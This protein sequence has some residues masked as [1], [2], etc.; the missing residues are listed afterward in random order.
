MS[1]TVHPFTRARYRKT[2]EGN[3]L[4]TDGDLDG[5]FARDGRWLE[6]S[7]YECDPQ[8]CVWVSGPK[9]VSHRLRPMDSPVEG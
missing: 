8:M 4:V 1:G 3:V 5:L 6:G 2:A 9:L 7:L